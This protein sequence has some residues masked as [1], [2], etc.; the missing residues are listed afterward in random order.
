MSGLFTQSILREAAIAYACFRVLTNDGS[1][2]ADAVCIETSPETSR[3]LAP[4]PAQWLGR[5]VSEVL[6]ALL[7]DADG[8]LTHLASVARGGPAIDLAAG[9][10]LTSIPCTVHLFSPGQN[11]VTLLFREEA[12]PAPSARV[13]EN[14]LSLPLLT[15]WLTVVEQG[16]DDSDLDP[17][18]ARAFRATSGALCAAIHRV[19]PD[20]SGFVTRGIDGL[21]ASIQ[22]TLDALDVHLV[23]RFWAWPCDTPP[24][25]PARGVV[26]YPDTRS[27][28]RAF[29][30]PD[31]IEWLAQWQ[32]G[33]VAVVRIHMPGS[34]PHPAFATLFMP[35]DRR[36]VAHDACVA[37][38]GIAALPILP[39]P[40]RDLDLHEPTPT[41]SLPQDDVLPA[42]SGRAA[43]IETVFAQS[44]CALF[45][46]SVAPDGSFHYVR[47]NP[48]ALAT[49]QAAH[50]DGDGAGLTPHALFGPERGSRL[51]TH[52]SRCA[53][54]GG[55]TWFEEVLDTPQGGRVLRTVL[56]PRKEQGRVVSLYGAS[57]DIT[58]IRQTEETLRGH[59]RRS[60]LT[61]ELL[62]DAHPE[63]ARLLV[64][65]TDAAMSLTDSRAA[66]WLRLEMPGT[67]W[68]LDARSGTWAQTPDAD[69]KSPVIHTPDGVWAEAIRTGL[70]AFRNGVSRDCDASHD[71]VAEAIDTGAL[72]TE[73][74]Q[75]C[76]PLHDIGRIVAVLCVAGREQG[77]TDD[78]AHQLRIL[79]NRVWP[80]VERSRAAAELREDRALL[81]TA[82][83]ALDHAVMAIGGDGQIRI[84][85]DTACRL[86]GW[87]RDE[88][89]GQPL[90][91]VLSLL[92]EDT[93][94]AWAPD[95]G[96]VENGSD[97]RPD[98]LLL[99]A[100]DGSERPIALSILPISDREGNADGAVVSF[101]DI[102]QERIREESMIY[103]SYQDQLTGLY[104]RR[105]F[106][107][108]MRR[109]D[110]RRNL[111]ITLVMADV[112][113][114]KLT[115]DAFGHKMGD[116]LLRAAAD[117]LRAGCRADDIIARISGDEFVI[118]LPHTGS[119]EAT[120]I[121]S[122]IR[123]RCAST[124]VEAI[125]LSISFGWDTKTAVE[126]DLQGTLKRA[127]ERMYR[128]KLFDS[129]DVRSSTMK[130]IVQTLYQTQPHEKPRAEHVAEL[131]EAMGRELGLPEHMVQ[132]LRTASTLYD[133]GKIAIRD[134]IIGKRGALT[135][136]ERREVQRHAEIGY[137]IIS[138]V[139]ELAE[140]A[141]YVLLHHENWD[142]SGY[143]KGLSGE[144]TP[145]PSRIIGI[146]DAFDA[147]INQRPYRPALSRSEA[148]EVIR[149]EAGT[150]FDPALVELFLSQV[151]PK[152]QDAD[153]P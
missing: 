50:A 125:P 26:L 69:Q 138:S 109:L 76:V 108:E 24:L 65:L 101:R 14:P 151:V 152:Q 5:R 137:R 52:F 147:L 3:F 116:R 81:H 99:L 124:R 146:A 21:P 15:D 45:A 23:G 13:P 56:I 16:A 103:L 48:A 119:E 141:D 102:T 97:E 142:G 8:W 58:S 37:L 10:P 120:E 19:V 59:L 36:F 149:R 67:R 68:V 62:Q 51:A 112:N 33:E 61:L 6:P 12:V 121:V 49:G 60:E 47:A 1:A 128:Q 106:E 117:A 72:P 53:R 144:L 30:P 42:A 54:E 9:P 153:T 96:P 18:L 28:A 78:Q 29:L 57:S 111:P 32:S 41:P 110:T 70:P 143:P 122:R 88:A 139:N 145:L 17:L 132:E 87:P 35:P 38:A 135:D 63:P 39:T 79:A 75:L 34:A 92:N 25:P 148:M 131:C 129:P 82:L 86:T 127:D 27:F 7:T 105:F 91:T 31:Q 140:I 114:L 46:V 100:R 104:N 22:S 2:P 94:A 84:L 20:A 11:Y 44:P 40:A 113:S 98:N 123:E 73:T 71:R 95:S 89:M 55:L 133:I 90:A 126:E 150:K 4:H 80:A 107:E 93:R 74:T 136:E 66:A 64:R 130:T 115:N 83:M 43:E 134:E 118:L 85:N 77:Y